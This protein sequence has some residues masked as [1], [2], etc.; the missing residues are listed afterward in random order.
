ML[1]HTSFGVSGLAR[2]IAFYDVVLAPLGYVRIWT[3]E[4]AAG[5]GVPGNDEPFAIRQQSEVVGAPGRECHLAF[6]APTRDSV[7]RFHAAALTAGA[8]NEDAAGLCPEYGEGYYAAF[9]RDPDGYR[10]EA[11]CHE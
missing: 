11:V 6:G 9:V 3:T 1:D 7:E 2:S 5:Y 4:S 10:I 8:I